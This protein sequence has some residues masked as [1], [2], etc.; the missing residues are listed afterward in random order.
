M[1][2]ALVKKMVH[3]GVTGMPAFFTGF[4]LGFS[5]ILAIG[6][7]NVFV[8]RQGLKQQHVVA[9]VL[10]CAIS[11]ALLIAAGVGGLGIILAPIMQSASNWLFLGAGIWLACYGFLRA[12]D[13][14]ISTGHALDLE[15]G[16]APVT[17]PNILGVCAVM[18]WG[19]PHVYLD[20]VLLLGSFSLP[21][22]GAAKVSFAAGAMLASFVFFSLLG[23]GAQLL[24][25][26]M[27][28]TTAWRVLDAITAI[29]MLLFSLV[30]ILQ[31]SWLSE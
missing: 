6:A 24:A 3:F 13:A 29:I 9:V 14:F 18:T 12:R 2:H 20:T 31:T 1:Y 19:N 21:F 30:M 4:G 10:F 8:L 16:Q 17:L 23:F 25:P 22:E 15:A 7:Q 27:R 11:D 5:L 28:S 26:Y